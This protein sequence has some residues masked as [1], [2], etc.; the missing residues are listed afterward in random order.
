MKEESPL[1]RLLFELADPK[2]PLLTTSLAYLSHLKSSEIELFKQTWAK[3]S[4]ERQYQVLSRL[5]QLRDNN[6]ELNFETI[7]GFCLQSPDDKIR[8]Q[9]VTGLEGTEDTSFIAPLIHLL[10]GDRVEQIRVAASVVLSN[11][12]LLAEL[13]KLSAAHGARIYS[14]LVGVLEKEGESVELKRRALEAVAPFSSPQVKEFI[15]KAYHS[16]NAKLKAS[17]IYAMGRHCDSEWLPTVI[18]ELS[19]NEA[20]IRYEAAGACGEL[21]AEEAVPHLISLLDDEEAQVQ[22]AAIKALGEIGGE[23]AKEVLRHLLDDADE[24]VR[25]AAKAALSELL[26]WEEPLSL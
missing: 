1:A 6:P 24:R 19:N 20:E 9:A 14:A 21:E 7:F 2:K 5:L 26:F 10:E 22:E 17:A 18:K 13:G 16:N 3:I 11:F 25:E 23:E 4:S 15:D 12:A 8:L